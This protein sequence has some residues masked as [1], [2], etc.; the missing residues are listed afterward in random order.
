[1][2]QTENY[3]MKCYSIKA[4]IKVDILSIWLNEIKLHFV[5]PEDVVI[6][7]DISTVIYII[8]VYTNIGW[9]LY[10]ELYIREIII[11]TDKIPL[12]FRKRGITMIFAK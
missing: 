12:V 9:W 7:N 2:Y 10:L 1:L 11:N 4:V 8:K 5:S 3:N 6:V